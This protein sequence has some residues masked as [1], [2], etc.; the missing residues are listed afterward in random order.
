MEGYTAII[1]RSFS[2][3]PSF[4]FDA[5]WAVGPNLYAEITNLSLRV[6]THDGMVVYNSD[7]FQF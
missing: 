4:A 5:D 2:G 1:G 7:L 6:T 3:S